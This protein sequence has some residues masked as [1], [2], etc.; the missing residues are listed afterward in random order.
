MLLMMNSFRPTLVQPQMYAY[1]S[2]NNELYPQG[3]NYMV[4][5]SGV[6]IIH[7]PNTV[8][9]TYTRYVGT[10]MY[11]PIMNHQRIANVRAN[12]QL[13]ETKETNE[14]PVIRTCHSDC[15]FLAQLEG[16]WQANGPGGEILRIVVATEGDD[17]YAIV[18]RFGAGEDRILYVED[19]RFTLCSLNDDVEAVALKGVGKMHSLT[20]YKNDGKPTF[21]RR[22][23]KPVTAD[24]LNSVREAPQFSRA[25]LIN[26][27]PRSEVPPH[28]G[29]RTRS[30]FCEPNEDPVREFSSSTKVNS[31]C[32][33]DDE[34][35]PDNDLFYLCQDFCKD[36]VILQKVLD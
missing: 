7:V 32:N 36:P 27:V 23:Y 29:V 13:L 19:T 30:A 3:P 15:N 17:E 25:S 31:S 35:S 16:S 24:G 34:D 28:E 2:V 14:P 1:S 4:S 22:I 21:W 10:P 26:E 6:P 5:P 18:R 8:P 20:W 33:S 12:R 9:V 11:L